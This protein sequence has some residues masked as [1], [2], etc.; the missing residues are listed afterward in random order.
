VRGAWPIVGYS[1]LAAV[2]PSGLFVLLANH[3][4]PRRETPDPPT[5][6][7]FTDLA[8]AIARGGF[9]PDWKMHR[10]PELP[11]PY[12]LIGL[13]CTLGANR[14]EAT[15]VSHID[16]AGRPVA[17]IELRG[18]PDFAQMAVHLETPDG[19]VTGAVLRR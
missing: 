19:R 9:S 2:L 12:R 5:S 15:V 10:Q 13:T 3:I 14:D 17:P 1:L 16:P 4:V 7:P 18:H 6:V 8:S 11:G